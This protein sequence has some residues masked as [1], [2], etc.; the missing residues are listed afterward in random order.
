MNLPPDLLLSLME[1]EAAVSGTMT[2]LRGL[3]SARRRFQ[4]LAHGESS[5]LFAEPVFVSGRQGSRLGSHPLLSSAWS[6]DREKFCNTILDVARLSARFGER[7]KRL[8][9]G[10]INFDFGFSKDSADF[11]RAAAGHRSGRPVP[12][13]AAAAPTS[14][15]TP[16]ILDMRVAELAAAFGRDAL[17]TASEL[18]A[19]KSHVARCLLEILV[20]C[21]NLTHLSLAGADPKG[22]FQSLAGLKGLP[23]GFSLPRLRHLDLSGLVIP[24]SVLRR[25]LHAC[26]GTL[27][28]LFLRGT[29]VSL[30]L[31]SALQGVGA[32]ELQPIMSNLPAIQE[33]YLLISEW[34]LE[35]L[36]DVAQRA[37]N[38]RTPLHIAVGHAN[39]KMLPRRIIMTSTVKLLLELGAKK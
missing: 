12:R 23:A 11:A 37:G 10:N 16:W 1:K 39:S 19:M 33:L 17:P 14:T 25:L 4:E 30:D 35:P 34:K 15:S 27:E 32:D 24:L 5:T 8:H 3:A 13:P 20:A 36:V 22:A 38:R 6:A 28:R 31:S 2:V 18:S 26:S 9:L 21:P 7:I 29:R